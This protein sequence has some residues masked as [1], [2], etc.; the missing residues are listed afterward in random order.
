VAVS[1][2]LSGT[3]I[4]LERQLLDPAVR[5]DARRLGALL[6]PAFVE[7]GRSGVQYSRAEVLREFAGQPPA[8]RVAGTDWAVSEV[9]PGVALVT[10]R[11]EHV[12]ESGEG[13]RLTLRS[14]LWVRRDDGSWTVR[15]H[16]GT[17]AP[18]SN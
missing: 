8:H 7:I 11:T 12:G 13:A 4:G 3:L 15:F 10:Y 5:A 14:S 9:A 6:H 1:A 18:A 2:A 17:A 16:Q